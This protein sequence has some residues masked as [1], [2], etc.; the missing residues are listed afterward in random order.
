MLWF[1]FYSLYSGGPPN[2]DA[3]K[4]PLLNS[5][6]RIIKKL[7]TGVYNKNR[8]SNLKLAIINKKF[9]ARRYLSFVTLRDNI[10]YVESVILEDILEIKS[11]YRNDQ[12]IKTFT[13]CNINKLY[14]II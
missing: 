12:R 14:L 1:S 13:N 8:Q 4:Y 6:F 5:V 9:L 7:A 2:I 10:L 3:L 11:Q